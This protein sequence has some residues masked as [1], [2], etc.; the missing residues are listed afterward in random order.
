MLLTQSMAFTVS[1][2]R[3]PVQR[4]QRAA[5]A[6]R[7]VKPITFRSDLKR[8]PQNSRNVVMSSIQGN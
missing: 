5:T 7:G 8:I 6:A 1:D 2:I 3:G 4:K